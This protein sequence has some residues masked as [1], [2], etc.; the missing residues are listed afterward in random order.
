[1][2]LLVTHV[3]LLSKFS[4]FYAAKLF[5]VF[6]NLQKVIVL[7]QV[8]TILKMSLNSIKLY[9]DFILLQKNQWVLLKGKTEF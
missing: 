4:K 6:K 8:R 3:N 5:E 1:M 9:I 2:L 7:K